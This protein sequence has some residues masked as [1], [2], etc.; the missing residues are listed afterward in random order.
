MTSKPIETLFQQM[1]ESAPDALVLVNLE[2]TIVQ[3]NARTEKMFG[4]PRE[5]LLGQPVEKLIPKRDENRHKKYRSKFTPEPFSGEMGASHDT[6]ARRKDGS[7]LLVDIQIN[8]LKIGEESQVYAVIRDITER[9]RAE[10]LQEALYR[11]SQEAIKTEGLD[12]LFRS[13]HSVLGDLLPVQNF[14]IALFDPASNTL[15]F[16]YYVDLYDGPVPPQPIGRGLTEY[17]LRTGSPLLA[18]PEVFEQLVGQGEVELLGRNSVDWLGVPLN[19]EDRTIGVM[20]AQSYTEGVRFSQRDVDVMTFVS[21]QVAMAVERKRAEENLRI[22]EERFKQVAE[23]AGE[24]IWEIDADGLYTYTNPVVEKIL[25]YQP[26]EIVGK[27]YFYNLFP[28]N[29]REELKAAAFQAS[30]NREAIKKYIHTKMHKNGSLVLMETSGLP[31]MDKNGNL[32]GYRG[33]DT[34]ITE[35]KRGED[36]MQRRVTE[37]AALYESGLAFNQLLDVEA[38]GQKIIEVLSK[39][40]N[41]HCATVCLRGEGSD[42]IE[43][44]AFSYPKSDAADAHAEEIRIRS[45]M[46]HLGEGIVGWVIQHGK[47]IRSGNISKDPRYIETY[48]N[49]ASGMYVPMKVGN[50][51]IGCISVESDKPHAFEDQDELLLTTLADQAALAIS[52]ARL[53]AEAE[54]RLR[55][56]EALRE[57]DKVIIS[58]VDLRL[59]LT[60]FLEQATKHLGVDA[61]D[62]LLLN[63]HVQVLE[64]AAGRGFRTGGIEHT[65]MRVGEGHTGRAALERQI[66]HIPDLRASTTGPLRAHI[67]SGE[68]FIAYY[69]VPLIAKGQVKGV[70]EIFHRSPLNAD[71]DWLDFLEALASQASIAIDNA[72]LF[73]GL[74]RSN[75]DLTLAYDATIQGWS[76]ALDLRDRETEGHTQRVTEMTMKLARVMKVSDEDLVHIRR[77][78]LLHDIGKMAVPDSILLKTGPLDD[79][80]WKVMQQH[81]QRSYDMLFPIT[82]LRPAL[83]I[84]YSHHERWDG[85]GYP[86]GLKDDSI[87]LA[88]RIFAVVDVYDALSSNRPYRPALTAQEARKYIQANAGTHFDPGVVEA[89]TTI[90][91][92]NEE[93]TSV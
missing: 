9:K 42:K 73:N 45:Q 19:I 29:L 83:D 40:L 22:S 93:Q 23:T 56:T 66:I 65:R 18:S 61:V 46:I 35:R 27:K 37:L 32:L 71:K 52:N 36:A 20:V 59:T 79:N 11:I 13:I 53:L 51:I 81:P 3:V 50:N 16:P 77:G 54:H 15:S 44:L 68:S 84:P 60:I 2:G 30:A 7:E 28:E 8:P 67:L 14:Y 58:S 33:V 17:V 34:D 31:S 4:Y 78:C 55:Q 12:E 41:W 92:Y 5:E 63:P 43:L 38:I 57:I 74:Q 86:Q 47:T 80:E 24:W 82:Y 87:P 88:A 85:S 72:T 69:A 70:L 64:Y 49:I 90:L 39:K 89:F 10:I 48:A 21:S 75:V 76:R 6:W 25:G 26:K 1:M 62:V 91:L